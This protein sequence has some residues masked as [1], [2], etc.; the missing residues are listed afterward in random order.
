M[1]EIILPYPPSANRYWRIARGKLIVSDAAKEFKREAWVI[2]C[3]GGRVEK[4]QGNVSLSVVLHPKTGSGACLDLD[5]ALK[6][7]LDALQGIVY[8]NDKQVVHISARK[9]EKAPGG[10]LVVSWGPAD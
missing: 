4:I 6:I 7:T 5:N 3:Q 9:R 10:R 8:D 2:A 1:P